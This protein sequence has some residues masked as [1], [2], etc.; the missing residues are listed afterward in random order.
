MLRK[1]KIMFF[2]LCS[3]IAFTSSSISSFAASKSLIDS[4]MIIIEEGVTE[5]GIPYVMYMDPSPQNDIS[6]NI[7][8]SKNYSVSIQ[9]KGNATP[10]D[11]WNT[12][13]TEDGITYSGTLNL[14][15]YS[16][17]NLGPSKYTVARYSGTLFA[18]I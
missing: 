14:E 7:V 17:D 6:P 18:R 16:Y 15:Y 4:S 13:F 1:F 2:A 9:F 5:D 12:S 3:L 11:T 8:V 10:P